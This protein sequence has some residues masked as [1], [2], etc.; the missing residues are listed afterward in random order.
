LPQ[1][2]VDAGLDMEKFGVAIR[3]GDVTKRIKKDRASGI[4]CGVNGTPC[5]FINGVRYD[6]VP[7]FESLR[8]ALEE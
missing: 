6:D 1:R 8:A 3:H 5:F 4:S 2:A 7:D